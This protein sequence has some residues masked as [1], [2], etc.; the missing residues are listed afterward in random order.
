MMQ[1]HRNSQLQIGQRPVVKYR[2]GVSLLE[3][4]IVLVIMAGIAALAWPNLQ[5]SIQRTYLN[6][7]ANIVRD[8]LAETKYRASIDGQ[9]YVIRVETGSN[10]LSVG[11]IEQVLPERTSMHFSTSA[12]HELATQDRGP[13]VR[14]HILPETV[15]VSQ[16]RWTAED[17]IVDSESDFSS[18]IANDNIEESSNESSK[19][20]FEGAAESTE[21]MAHQSFWLPI[22]AACGQGRDVTIT[23]TD[24][25]AKQSVEV[26]YCAATGNVEVVR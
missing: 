5:R 7:S 22:L 2:R 18:T 9:S 1:I 12:K 8:L 23:L 15:V 21:A 19:T 24:T 13:S 20:D 4:M 25:A 11:S 17:T 6:E 26:S 10:E 3:V 14:S 16:V